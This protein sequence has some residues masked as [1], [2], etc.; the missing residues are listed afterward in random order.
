MHVNYWDAPDYKD[1][2]AKKSFNDFL[3]RYQNLWN[4]KHA[5]APTV[6]LNG[7]EWGGWSHGQE[8]PKI[9][10][11]DVGVL[12][13]D[14]TKSEDHFLVEFAPSKEV[15]TYGL[16]AHATLLGFGLRSK[17]AEGENQG[18]LLSHDFIA[19]IY[20]EQLLQLSYGVW[21]ADFEI[22][23]KKMIHADQYAIVFWVTSGDNMRP[24]QVAGGYL[25]S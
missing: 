15:D 8:I 13:V 18:H 24:I 20:Q 1:A 3:L 23:P 10:P 11:K 16:T 19:L 7:T 4:M 9:S 25:P 22:S 12:S 2:F 17:P 21:T 5:Y 14:G 6:V